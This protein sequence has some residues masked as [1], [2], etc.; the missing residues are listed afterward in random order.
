M[1][2]TEVTIDL[3]GTVEAAEQLWYD[4]AR[5]AAFMDGF[6]HVVRLDESW[7]AEG[8]R[9]VWDSRPG[10][11]GRVAELVI[12]YRA[13]VGQTLEVEDERLEGTQRV[14]FVAQEGGVAV[15]LAIA[16]E[17][18]RGG[19]ARPFIDLFVRRAVQESLRRT[20]ERFGTELQADLELLR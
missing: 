9:L 8:A 7:P 1:A 18:K 12:E 10:G 4:P 15:Q 6:A 5:W 17:L 11:R 3:D 16:Y 2:S 14:R 13:G 19:P 20:L